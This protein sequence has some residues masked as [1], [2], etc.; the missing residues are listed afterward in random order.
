MNEAVMNMLSHYFELSKVDAEHAI[1]IYKAFAK[2][3]DQVIQ[4]LGIARQ[5]EHV[6][7]LEIPKI[8]HAP[9]SLAASLQEYIDDNDFETNRRQYLAE[10]QVKDAPR[11]GS[12]AGKKFTAPISKDTRDDTRQFS[13][14]SSKPLADTAAIKQQA[15]PA[16]APAPAPEIDFFG[17]IE[18][19][20]QPVAQPPPQAQQFMQPPVQD[21]SQQPYGQP[22]ANGAMQTGQMSTNPYGQMAASTNPFGQVQNPQYQQPQ[23]LQPDFTG[24]GFGGFGPQPP[25]QQPQQTGFASSNPFGMQQGPQQMPQQPPQA[26]EQPFGVQQQQPQQQQ[27]QQ[28]IPQIQQPPQ[29]QMQPPSTNP[30]RQSMMITGQ[31]TGFP[32]Q[33]QPQQQQQSTNPF[34]RSSPVQAGAPFSPQQQQQTG[35]FGQQQSSPSLQP[36]PTGTNPFARQAAPTQAPQQTGSP[37]NFLTPAVTGSTNPFRQSAFVNQQTGQGWQNSGQGTIGGWEQLETTPV[38][39]RLG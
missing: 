36:Q 14:S 5:Y 7:K 27:Q 13:S 35:P 15:A 11:F 19:P 4:Y 31:N 16:P 1:S 23:P 2:Q 28:Q 6:T 33:Q 3:T 8:K 29:Q 24:A 9:T 32:M 38:F 37:A 18:Q 26:F 25:Q 30:F 17:S 20:P 39:P 12:L 21:F 22:P 10:Q 34:A